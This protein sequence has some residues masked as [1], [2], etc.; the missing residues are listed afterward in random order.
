ME[1]EL[2]WLHRQLR[3]IAAEVGC[4]ANPEPATPDAIH[5][6]LLSGLLSHIGMRDER[7]R[8]RNL[9]YQGARGARFAIAGGSALAKKGPRS[10]EPGMARWFAINDLTQWAETPEA[11]E[12]Y[13]LRAQGQDDANRRA[14]R[15]I[16]A[17]QEASRLAVGR[18]WLPDTARAGAR[19]AGSPVQA[20]L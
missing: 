13:V 5:R 9:E 3:R 7:S 1:P 20:L 15:C 4:H 2:G 11:M 10:G 18:G 8:D 19:R 6:S 14:Q 16:T 17:V 12:G